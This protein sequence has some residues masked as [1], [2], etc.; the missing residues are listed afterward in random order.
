MPR[1]PPSDRRAV[2]PV[3]LDPFQAA[4][5]RFLHEDVAAQVGVFSGHFLA[6]IVQRLGHVQFAVH[7]ADGLRMERVAHQANRLAGNAQADRDFRA[8]RHEV[9]VIGEGLAAQQ[10]LFMPAVEA[11]VLAQQAGADGDFRFAV[12][13]VLDMA[14]PR[15]KI[16]VQELNFCTTKSHHRFEAVQVK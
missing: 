15:C 12:T 4:G 14:K 3:D 9:E 6:V 10:G 16:P 13:G 7:G 11:H 5:R 1:P 8:Q 2:F